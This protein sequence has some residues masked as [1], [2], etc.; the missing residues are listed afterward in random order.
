MEEKSN[1]RECIWSLHRADAVG[2]SPHSSKSSFPCN[3]PTAP[4]P[5]PSRLRNAFLPST[6]SIGCLVAPF[7]S[8][9][10]GFS[11]EGNSLSLGRGSLTP[12]R[13]ARAPVVRAFFVRLCSL[14]A[15]LFVIVTLAWQHTLVS[16]RAVCVFFAQPVISVT[17]YPE[18]KKK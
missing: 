17:A 10:L 12:L 4:H 9:L 8:F 5:P 3:G 6:F 7:R 16:A 13:R 14:V 15:V 11:L 1:I 18:K 2:V